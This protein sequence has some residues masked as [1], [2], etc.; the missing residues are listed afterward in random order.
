MFESFSL[1][2][3][4]YYCRLLGPSTAADVLQLTNTFTSVAG[5]TPTRV[6]VNSSDDFMYNQREDEF[7][8]ELFQV[9]N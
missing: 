3:C 6:V 9:G 1:K 5:P 4:F 7:Y 8:E 2:Y